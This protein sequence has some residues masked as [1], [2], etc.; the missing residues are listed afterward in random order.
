MVSSS[1]FCV[2]FA[3]KQKGSSFML[4]SQLFRVT[5]LRPKIPE[6]GTTGPVRLL[7][8]GGNSLIAFLVGLLY[9]SFRRGSHR[10]A[11]RES[12]LEVGW[13]W[14]GDLAGDSAPRFSPAPPGARGC[15]AC[16]A[17]GPEGKWLHADSFGLSPKQR[18]VSFTSR[19]C[20]S[21]SPSGGVGKYI[22]L[23]S[24][25]ELQKPMA[26]GVKP[27]RGGEFEPIMQ[28]VTVLI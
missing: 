5:S 28:S 3:Q 16:S 21:M 15:Q 10:P 13:W 11:V 14:L 24:C 7:S 9:W 22:L 27:E 1:Y 19:R 4:D 6:S 26:K 20:H 25:E 8:Q 12:L 17:Q 18:T 2:T 23:L